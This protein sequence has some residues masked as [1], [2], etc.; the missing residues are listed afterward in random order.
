MYK[1]SLFETRGPEPPIQKCHGSRPW[2]NTPSRRPPHA[3]A[4][5]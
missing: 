4:D 5:A 1:L 3:D 2:T